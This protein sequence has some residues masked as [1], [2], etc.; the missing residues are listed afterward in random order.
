MHPIQRCAASN[1]TANSLRPTLHNLSG[2]TF[3]HYKNVG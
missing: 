2:Y 3:T 1:Q